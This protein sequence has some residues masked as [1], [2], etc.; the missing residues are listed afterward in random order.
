[1]R[2]RGRFAAA[3]A[4]VATFAGPAAACAAQRDQFV[5]SF[6]GTK[7]NTHFFVADG[8][9]PG[10]RAPTVMLAHGYGEQGPSTPD[11]T[12]A[13][14]PNVGRLMK[15]GYNVLTWDARGHGQSGGMAELDNPAVEG[16]DTRILIDFIAR[17]P[18]AQLDA[19]GDPRVGMCG[20]SYGGL[21][22]W[23]VA[24]GDPH[25]DVIEPAY[26]AP[27]LAAETSTRYGDVKEPWLAPIPAAGA[28]SIPGG[29]TSPAGPS[30][31][32]TDPR[33]ASE[34]AQAVANG[35]LSDNLRA[36][37]E[38]RSATHYLDR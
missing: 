33:L 1:M 8:L 32:V 30:L 3:I 5:T 12:L 14:A 2:N 29:L 15:A 27:P 11:T 9:K 28:Q 35:R 17:Q 31:H 19:P 18:E 20:A 21:I 7:I 13:G 24:G 34:V 36:E 4:V 22:Q 25:V 23:I 6:D 38:V 16:R 10:E 26:T 37:L